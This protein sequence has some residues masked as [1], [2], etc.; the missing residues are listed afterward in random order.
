VL[1]T[2]NA[3][4]SARDALVQARYAHLQAVLSLYSA[5]GGGWQNPD[6]KVADAAK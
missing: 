5:L 3:L 6:G 2:Q 1:N 4:F